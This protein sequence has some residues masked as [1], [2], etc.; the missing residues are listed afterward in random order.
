M[1]SMHRFLQIHSSSLYNTRYELIPWRKLFDEKLLK[2]L[3]ILYG[4]H[5]S[6]LYRA[7]KIPSLVSNLIQGKFSLYEPII[8][9]RSTFNIILPFT[10][11]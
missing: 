8:F 5:K 7:H 3:P 11:M 6:L 9:L 4:N 1:K 10:P 2:K